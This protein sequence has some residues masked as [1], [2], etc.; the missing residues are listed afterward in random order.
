MKGSQ[1][2]DGKKQG[3]S[4]AEE[5]RRGGSYGE[6]EGIGVLNA[7]VGM[8]RSWDKNREDWGVASEG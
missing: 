5:E 4:D 7:E 1:V 3:H 2:D 6:G 8:A